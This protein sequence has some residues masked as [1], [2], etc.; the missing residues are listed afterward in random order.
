MQDTKAQKENDY[1]RSKSDFPIICPHVRDM[2]ELSSQ[3]NEPKFA[4]NLK[5]YLTTNYS[6]EETTLDDAYYCRICGEVLFTTDWIGITNS[7]RAEGY[8]H[9]EDELRK[10]IWKQVN[11]LLRTEIEFKELRTE[12][13]IKLV[14]RDIVSRLYPFIDQIEKKLLKIK[15]M[16]TEELE[17]YKR[18]LTIIYCY[19]IFIRI[20]LDNS[21]EIKFKAFDFGKI[22]V[23][24]L[25][26]YATDQIIDGQNVIINTMR[27]VTPEYVSSM[28]VKAYD[29][30]LNHTVKT[31]MQAPEPMSLINYII[32][33][34][35]YWFLVKQWWAVDAKIKSGNIETRLAQLALPDKILGQPLSKIEAASSAIFEHAPNPLA[36]M[37][38]WNQA[39]LVDASKAGLDMFNRAWTARMGATAKWLLD[40]TKS[41][42]YMLPYW[43]VSI[44]PSQHGDIIKVNTNPDYI[45]FASNHDTESLDR[46]IDHL[47]QTYRCPPYAKLYD[48]GKPRTYPGFTDQ[49]YQ[50][51]AYS[52]GTSTID[53]ANK[54]I[55]QPDAQ[56]PG[57]HI[58]D[59]KYVGFAELADLVPGKKLSAY[60]KPLVIKRGDPTPDLTGYRMIDQY[61]SKCFRAWSEVPNPDIRSELER[62]QMINGFYNYFIK[63]CPE[64]SDPT[65]TMHDFKTPFDAGGK[66][67]LCGFSKAAYE[68]QDEKYFKSYAA[69]FKKILQVQE[70][71]EKPPEFVLHKNL[72]DIDK[73]KYNP[74][75]TSEFIQ[76]TYDIIKSG[77]VTETD[78]HGMTLS[79]QEYTN[80]INNMGMLTGYDY[81]QIRR[82]TKTPS[83]SIT[84][85]LARIRRTTIH[86]Y[87][88]TILIEL[89]RI[90]NP[91]DRD[92]S[93]D[94]IMDQLNKTE[95]AKLDPSLIQKQLGSIPYYE[96]SQ[97]LNS[98][99]PIIQA[100]YTY[101][102]LMQL[103]LAVHQTMSKSKSKYKFDITIYLIRL[104]IDADEL[105]TRIKPQRAAALE[106]TNQ[107]TRDP[108]T[109][110][111]DQ[112]RTFDKLVDPDASDK[113]G[114]EEMDYD[115]DGE[116]F[117]KSKDF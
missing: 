70:E 53:D 93:L 2:M 112:A 104:I 86:P 37:P 28:L 74:N 48:L 9:N 59:W 110:D 39:A 35:L 67:K 57:T 96:V 25:I 22:N 47:W 14:I 69:S 26:K 23:D 63:I 58:H 92:P 43:Q 115:D 29:A 102:Y 44:E 42:V 55:I 19:A 30:I 50:Y 82:G 71:F 45:K 33:D 87:I 94:K 83:K 109:V 40:Y 76:I 62:E 7:I 90:V 16:S 18:L 108:N 54:K 15:T 117:G 80:I 103:I 84:P 81:D 1:L 51:I 38:A 24:K 68:D 100:N 75:I 3:S 99:D 31:K 105:T 41:G 56:K 113:Y 85:E 61:C 60:K 5:D 27:N 49:G 91:C 101:E 79:K 111:N 98:V 6:T 8:G 95:L 20:I 34:P 66:C 88:Q 52:H 89:A 78:L 4:E 11:W 32:A 65:N 64:Q 97:Y 77:T 107:P 106:A 12:Q 116:G 17:N 10:Y 73:W 36:K 114:Y 46:S 13:D 72:T 21:K